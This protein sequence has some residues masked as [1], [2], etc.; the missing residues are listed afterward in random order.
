M[1]LLDRLRTSDSADDERP[2][3]LARDAVTMRATLTGLHAE[4]GGA[5]E[6]DLRGVTRDLLEGEV[7]APTADVRRLIAQ[8]VDPQ[9][10]YERELAPSW[11]G[12]DEM[13]RADKLD[14]FLELAQ[15]MEASPDALP[16]DMAASLRTK[17]LILAWAFDE[18]HGYLGQMAAGG[19][20]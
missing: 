2:P 12:L 9:E 20:G 11:D 18:A 1:G 5:G 15:M 8:D 10:F 13:A 17:L 7:E 4:R 19:T 14:G 16:R 3:S 6:P